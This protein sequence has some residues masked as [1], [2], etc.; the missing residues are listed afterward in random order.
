MPRPW[1]DPTSAPAPAP[2]SVGNEPADRVEATAFER[3][4]S[5]DGASGDP[6]SP[7]E[8]RE[9]FQVSPES[10]VEGLLFVGDPQGDG[11]AARAIAAAI[12]GTSPEEVEQI[13]ER[14]NALYDR[15]AAAYRIT[16]GSHG[17]RLQ[18]REELEPVRQ[19]FL[20]RVRE[21]RLSHAAIEVLAVVA[22]HQPVAVEQVDRLR[23]H[24]SGPILNQLVRRDLLEARVDTASG[25]RRVYHTTRRFLDLFGLESIEDIPRA[26]L[27]NDLEL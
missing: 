19:R 2:S 10:I 21:A 13:V 8:T 9:P 15:E 24:A 3:T 1:P 22:Y 4:S 17:F 16:G 18:L 11:L 27:D 7:D 26:V 23:N 6:D 14:L 5:E 20:G 25:R 12:R